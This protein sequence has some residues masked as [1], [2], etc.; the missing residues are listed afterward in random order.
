MNFKQIV[1]QW[2]L[3][4]ILRLVIGIVI[5]VDGLQRS[6]TFVV[7]LGGAFALLAVFNIGCG[8]KGCA[9][10]TIKMDK[11]SNDKEKEVVYEEV[12]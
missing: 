10:P 7:L 11:N 9:T 12:L 5:L 1:K 8:P 4:R 2:N 3:M 6:E